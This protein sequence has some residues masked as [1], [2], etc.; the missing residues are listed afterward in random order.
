MH[1]SNNIQ[2]INDCDFPSY[3]KDLICVYTPSREL[4]SSSDKFLLSKPFK[5]LDTFG[6]KSFHYA[7]PDVWNTL[8]YDIRSC[9][10]FT[11]FK[12]LLKTHFFKLAFD[13]A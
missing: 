10:N 1:I 7:A 5:K 4:R 3:L 6:K 8:P 9:S 11:S 12:K 2:C 13:Q